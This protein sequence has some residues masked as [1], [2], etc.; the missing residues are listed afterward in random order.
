[1]NRFYRYL[2]L[3]LAILLAAGSSLWAAPKNEVV[4]YDYFGV[5]SGESQEKFDMFR[6]IL[7]T[8]ITRMKT[9]LP[10]ALGGLE[11]ISK[12][13]PDFKNKTTAMNTDD[14]HL[15]LQNRGTALV[16]LTGTVATEDGQNYLVISHIH[17]GEL[18]QYLPYDPIVI[19][20]PISVTEFGNIQD[21]HSLV[22]FYALAMDA[23]RLGA[24][25]HLVAKLLAMAKE[26]L[27]DVD[28]RS[29]QLSADLVVLKEAIE[30]AEAELLG[31]ADDG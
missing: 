21:S 14:I 25:S 3:P 10:A 16:L 26:K 7:N 27:A 12:L 4:V 24:E 20:L 11:H 13:H 5:G 19:P 28:A 1:M 22:I 18:Q 17:L 29:D 9:Q 15:W 30:K 23:R 8:K 6:G 2:A 31:G